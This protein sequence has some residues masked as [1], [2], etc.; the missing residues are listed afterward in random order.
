M[1]K[2]ADTVAAGGRIVG[3][4]RP[5]EAVE[6]VDYD[7]TWPQRFEDMRGRLAQALGTVAVRIDHVGSTAI[8]GLPA[9]PVVDIQVSVLDVEDDES[10]KSPIESLGFELRWIETGHRYF[11]RPPGIPRLQQIHVCSTGSRWERV[12][13][14]FRDYLLANPQVA[15]EYAALKKR[16]AAKHGEHRIE[17]NDDKAGFIDAVVAAAED[18]A[19]ETG[20]SP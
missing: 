15:A 17:Y 9:K 6:I 12:H 11:R 18:W 10:Y 1:P 8:P 19:T 7:P 2:F 4:D 3:R 16:L 14:L 20:W 5:G 13:L